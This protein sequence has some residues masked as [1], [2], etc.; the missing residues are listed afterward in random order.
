[1]LRRALRILAKEEK[2]Q[3]TLPQEKIFEFFALG[4]EAMEEYLTEHPV[5]PED[6]DVLIDRVGVLLDEFGDDVES[7]IYQVA[8]EYVVQHG[9][10]KELGRGG[11]FDVEAAPKIEEAAGYI[12]LEED[13]SIRHPPAGQGYLGAKRTEANIMTLSEAVFDGLQTAE[14]R[15]IEDRL[16]LELGSLIQPSE[17]VGE[18]KGHATL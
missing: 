7:A 14:E 17:G 9:H 8:T 1:M 5:P 13:E 4:Q 18:E 6:M 2:I 16:F 11:W 3:H 12:K 15:N 10:W